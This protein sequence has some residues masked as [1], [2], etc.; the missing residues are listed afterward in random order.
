MAKRGIKTV[1]YNA[2]R[3][4]LVHK[5]TAASVVE[6]AVAKEIIGESAFTRQ[7]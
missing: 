7:E 5:N 4:G 6:A 2:H 1:F 3:S